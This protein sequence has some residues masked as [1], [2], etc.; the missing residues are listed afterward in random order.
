MVRKNLNSY[1]FILGVVI[2]FFFQITFIPE[3]FP[4]S[5]I[6]NLVLAVLV[7]G[8]YLSDDNN[9]LYAA[10]VTG[11]L[12]DI[13][14]G[15]F[16]GAQMISFLIAVFASMYAAEHYVK[17]LYSMSMVLFLIFSVVLY[18]LSYYAITYIL[19]NSQPAL[20]IENVFIAAISD[21]LFLLVTVYILIYIFSHNKK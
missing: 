21:T 7:S 14:S 2:S 18:N 10:F 9:I 4:Q 12:V 15:K 19:N 3:I 17:E 13:Y 11:Y 20:E 6:P 16:F 8:A 1:I 5:L